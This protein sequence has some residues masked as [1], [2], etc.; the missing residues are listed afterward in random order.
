V[1]FL[2]AKRLGLSLL[3]T[4]A[5]YRAVTL[6][7]LEQEIDLDDPVALTNLA[8]QC[9][10]ELGFSENPNQVRLNGKDVTESIRTPKVTDLAYKVAQVEGVRKILADQ[11]RRIAARGGGLVTEGRDQG[12]VVFSDADIKFY[13]DAAASC[14]ARRRWR[15]LQEAPT[16]DNIS[17]QEV[18]LAQEQRD[19]RDAGRSAS[20]LK[21]PPG[22]IIVDTTGMSI[23]QVVQQL[24]GYVMEAST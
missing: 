13:L 4:G 18:L 22:A 10:I 21:I 17:Y 11:Q 12:T 20:P 15:Q 23:E 2:L 16:N 9:R 1:A 7:A 19:A 3:D 14:R 5:M 24:Y 8:R 6:A